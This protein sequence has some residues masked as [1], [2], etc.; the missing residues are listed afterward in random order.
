MA[1]SSQTAGSLQTASPRIRSSGDRTSASRWERD[2]KPGLRGAAGLTVIDGLPTIR[3]PTC[4]STASASTAGADAEHAA[5]VRLA[6]RRHR[7]ARL[8]RRARLRPG[9]AGDG[10]GDGGRRHRRALPDHRASRSSPATTWTRGSRSAICRGVQ[11]LDPR[12]LPATARISSSSVAML[13]VHDVHLACRELVRCVPRAGRGRLVHPAE[14]GQRP[15]LALE[16][17]GS[18]LQHARGART[19][20]GASTR[21]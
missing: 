10:H 9:G 17:L 11:Q 16:L 21:A 18:A 6:A 20:P 12:V 1:S 15:L 19:S 14:P 13:P 8:R 7:P 5:A 2:G 4:S 3:T